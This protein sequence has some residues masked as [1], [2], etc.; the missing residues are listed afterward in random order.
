MIFR[1][2]WVS[3][4]QCSVSEDCFL[5]KKEEDIFDLMTE[6]MELLTQNFEVFYSKAYKSASLQKTG[7]LSGKIRLE[8][9]IDF[10]EIDLDY[11]QIPKEELEEF[12]KAIRLNK[13]ASFVP[14]HG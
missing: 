13:T 8:S 14:C 2:G 9:G 1:R 10:L 4:K 5:L 6:H 3:G 11:S 12:F 7:F